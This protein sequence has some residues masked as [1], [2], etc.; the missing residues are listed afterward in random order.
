MI[1]AC[2]LIS[3]SSVDAYCANIEP[4]SSG[5]DCPAIFYIL[6][7]DTAILFADALNQLYGIE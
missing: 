1:D 4:N 3:D 6:P 5:N 2:A 7:E